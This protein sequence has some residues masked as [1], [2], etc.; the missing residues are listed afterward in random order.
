VKT[1]N[2]EIYIF[3]FAAIGERLCQK[4]TNEIL[5]FSDEYASSK[6]LGI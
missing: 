5:E 3:I 1:K 6:E 4:K 2:P